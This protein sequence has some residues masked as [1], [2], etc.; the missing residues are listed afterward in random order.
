RQLKDPDS[1]ASGLKRILAA[2]TK[3]RVGEAELLAAPE[4]KSPSVCLLALRLPAEGSW[5]VTAINFGRSPAE[6]EVNLA[7][8]FGV[9]ADLVRG[10]KVTD[11][12]AGGGGGGS[13]RRGRPEDQARC[14]G[15]QD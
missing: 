10:A 14:A 5:A 3:Y 6:E 15:G 1:F 7:R 2:R 9:P 4:A 12:L 8:A 11:A 13:D